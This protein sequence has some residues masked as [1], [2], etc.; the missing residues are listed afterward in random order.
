MTEWID[1]NKQLPPEETWVLGW[2]KKDEIAEA[3]IIDR[4]FYNNTFIGNVEHH[5]RDGHITHWQPLPKPPKV[6]K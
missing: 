2:N 4:D 5:C 6:E 3:V 1:I